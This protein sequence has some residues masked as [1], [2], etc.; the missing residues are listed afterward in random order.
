MLLPMR[1]SDEVALDHQQ[2]IFIIQFIQYIESIFKIL[3]IK[4]NFKYL[5]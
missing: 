4:K 3:Y 2:L 5:C 1:K